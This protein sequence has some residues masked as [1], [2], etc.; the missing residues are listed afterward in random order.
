MSSCA[1]IG[2]FSEGRKGGSIKEGRN[3]FIE[4]GRKEGWKEGRI[5][6]RR[7]EEWKNGR[8][9]GSIK[10]EGRKDGKKEK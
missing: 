8:T 4:E 2:P 6:K 5:H 1:F 3:G 7:T 9:E 10:K